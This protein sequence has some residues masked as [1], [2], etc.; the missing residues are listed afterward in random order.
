MK[1]LWLKNIVLGAGGHWVNAAS[2]G[3]LGG[4]GW[5]G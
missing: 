5:V 3:R 1:L 4:R 2:N